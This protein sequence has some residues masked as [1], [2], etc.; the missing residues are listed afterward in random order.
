MKI[1][2]RLLT[3]GTL[4]VSGLM[5]SNVA[6]AALSINCT[7]MKSDSSIDI[8]LGAGPVPNIVAVT[9]KVG[10][11]HL[12]TVSGQL[13]EKVVNAQ[14]Y[15]DGEI[16]RIDLIDPQAIKQTAAIRLVRRDHQSQPIQIGFYRWTMTCRLA[17]LAKGRD[18]GRLDP[19]IIKKARI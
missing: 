11:R 1:A 17:S 5:L 3:L 8:L 2:N 19:S 12:T 7:N 10:D 16:L 4:L 14:A 6:E 9:I 13:G 18:L 15:D